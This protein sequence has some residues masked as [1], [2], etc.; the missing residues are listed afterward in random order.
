MAEESNQ[1]K[2]IYVLYL[3]GFVL[4]ITPLI[5]VVMAY[6]AKG[7]APEWLVT[8]YR[9]QIRTFWIGFLYSVVSALLTVILIG[10]LG[11]L[12]VA[13][14]MIIR[15]VKGFQAADRGEPIENVE[16]WLF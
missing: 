4:G 2:I 11:L 16:S 7:S 3:A 5:G 6:M 15:C 13:V 14:W 9:Y 10:F 1:A 8:H 12:A